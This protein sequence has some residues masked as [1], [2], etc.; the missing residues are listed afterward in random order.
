MSTKMEPLAILKE[1]G[2]Q[3]GKRIASTNQFDSNVCSTRHHPGQPWEHLSPPG[4]IFRHKLN[5]T[6]GDHRVTLL[7]NGNFIAVHVPEDLDV[8]VC[9]INRCDK[10]FALRENALRV[11]NFPSFSVYSRDPHTDLRQLLNLEALARALNA[12]QLAERESL[13]FYRNGLCLY[14]QRNSKDAV[15]SAVEV[16][17][18]LTEQL[19]A[20]VHDS[21]N[22]AEI[23][24]K[25]ENLFGLISE[26]AVSDD[27]R[28]SEMLEDA[29]REKLKMFVASVSPYIPAINEYLDSFGD[30]QPPEAACALG[31]LAECCL[32]AQFQ[33]RDIPE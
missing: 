19:P 2:K 32:E 26:W 8:D 17:C 20:A 29:S 13:H 23:P 5:I 1:I 7:A 9:S 10:I 28:R 21:L 4:D 22:L 18:R 12:L 11:P 30:Q 6:F 31:T 3:S 25:F 16:A 33:L 24:G 27:E 14:L 15:M